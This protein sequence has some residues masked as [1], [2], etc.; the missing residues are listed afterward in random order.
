MALRRPIRRVSCLA[1]PLRS[2]AKQLG[3]SSLSRAYVVQLEPGWCLRYAPDTN[4]AIAGSGATSHS[5]ILGVKLEKPLERRSCIQI[6]Q[7]I[8]SAAN[9]SGA[10]ENR[11]QRG[12]RALTAIN[13]MRQRGVLRGWKLT[14]L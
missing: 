5:S 4:L 11:K 14:S 9:P 3:A 2:G 1:P 7:R 13:V 10:D 6:S 8:G 12:F